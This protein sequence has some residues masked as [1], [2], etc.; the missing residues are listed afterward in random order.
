MTPEAFVPLSTI[1]FLEINGMDVNA[2]LRD[3]EIALYQAAKENSPDAVR[4]QL[5]HNADASIQDRF[6][7]IALM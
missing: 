6:G 4:L 3:G 5:D 2:K 1:G 7:D